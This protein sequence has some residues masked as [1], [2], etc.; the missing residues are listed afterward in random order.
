MTCGLWKERKLY[1]ETKYSIKN[2]VANRQR[3][4]LWTNLISNK[5]IESK[6]RFENGKLMNKFDTTKLGAPEGSPRAV[7]ALDK[8]GRAVL[9]STVWFT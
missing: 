4:R 6:D 7:E 2:Y 8:S 5:L 9:L 1:F 3:P